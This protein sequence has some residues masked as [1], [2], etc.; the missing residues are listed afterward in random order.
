MQPYTL[1]CLYFTFAE[2]SLGRYGTLKGGNEGH[3]NET[4]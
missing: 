2:N 3:E 1:P 4:I